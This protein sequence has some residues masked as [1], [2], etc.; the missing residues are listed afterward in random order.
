MKKHSK[1]GRTPKRIHDQQYKSQSQEDTAWIDKLHSLRSPRNEENRCSTMNA[2]DESRLCP[3]GSRPCLEMEENNLQQQ[4][5]RYGGSPTSTNK[6]GYG[7]RQD[8]EDICADNHSSSNKYLIKRWER[9]FTT[10]SRLSFF[11]NG[12]GVG[13]LRILLTFHKHAVLTALT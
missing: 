13:V 2:S 7:E 1:F 8:E 11:P 4:K 12:F 3:N 5:Y 6:N 9:K 10:E